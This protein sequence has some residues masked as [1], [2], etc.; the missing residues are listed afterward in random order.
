MSTFNKNLIYSYTSQSIVVFSNFTSSILVARMVGAFGQGQLG[1]YI[2]FLTLLSLIIG[3]GIPS[4][5]VYYIASNKL[6]KEN[7]FSILFWG[8]IFPFFSI[9]IL[10]IVLNNF[11]LLTIFLPEFIL[12]SLKWSMILFLHLLFMIINQYYQSLLQAENN[13]KKSGITII[14]GSLLLLTLY[15][16]KYFKLINIPIQP[17]HWIILSLT[18]VSLVQIILF[19]LQLYKINTEY[20]N[21]KKIHFSTVK[22]LIIF[23]SLAFT[24]NV[25]QFLNYKMDIWIINYFHQNKDMIG[26]YVLSVALAQL[27]WILPNALHGVLFTFTAG[28]MTLSHKLLKAESSSIRL[29]L[30][31]IVLGI[32]G[33]FL[34]IYLVPYLFGETFKDV[35]QIIGILLIG[36]I[37]ISG[38]LAISAFFAGIEKI[39][40]NLF[41]SIIGLITCFLF[42]ILLIPKYNIFGAAWATVISY[43]CTV[44]FYYIVFYSFKNKI[45]PKRN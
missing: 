15:L 19:N 43:N 7:V 30:Y 34:S 1:L 12:S 32:M 27:V 6:R 33:Y 22:P 41:G 2:N 11:N 24:A 28:E 8:T 17:I 42:D 21:F 35:P 10:Y 36:I 20:F 5:L 29:L 14:S 18:T 16:T 31:S 9:G 3:F 40:I 39:K 45:I 26:V 4:A 37:P 44:I 13:F 38:A 25:V 23:S